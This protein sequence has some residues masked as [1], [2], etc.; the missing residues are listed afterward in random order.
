[1]CRDGNWFKDAH[2]FPI[3]LPNKIMKTYTFS[4]YRTDKYFIEV[5]AKDEDE[6]REKAGDSI[7]ELFNTESFKDEMKFRN[8]TTTTNVEQSWDLDRVDDIDEEEENDD[9][10]THEVTE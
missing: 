9:G 4:V 5:D 10:D 6:A 7:E 2:L 3:S 1:V 8:I